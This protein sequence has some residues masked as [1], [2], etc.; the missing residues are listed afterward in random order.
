ML[1]G[2]GAVRLK[3]TTFRVKKASFGSCSGQAG[4]VKIEAVIVGRAACDHASGERCSTG[5]G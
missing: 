5:G 3:S 4:A 2:E 1:V